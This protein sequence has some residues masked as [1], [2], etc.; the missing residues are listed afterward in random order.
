[1]LTLQAIYLCFIAWRLI[2]H[3][4]ILKRARVAL[5]SRRLAGLLT[6]LVLM[7]SAYGLLFVP[8]GWV[9]YLV[10]IW[11]PV[12]LGE[13]WALQYAREKNLPGATA[14]RLPIY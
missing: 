8:F 11:G 13:W 2:A 7:Y 12:G 1:M 6:S 9:L 14:K 5:F 4:E 3:A 10:A